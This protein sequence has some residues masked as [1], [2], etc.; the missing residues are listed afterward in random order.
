MNLLSYC[1]KET[2]AKVQNTRINAV[3]TKDI[4]K[5]GVLVYQDGKIGIS[6]AIGE[7]AEDKLVEN[8][9]R[10]LGT[11]ISYPYPLSKDRKDHRTYNDN[12][13]SA[14]ELMSITESV[15][16]TLRKEY[17]DFD[18]SETVST[19]EITIEMRNSEGLDLEYKDAYFSLGLILREKKSANL[20]DGLIMCVMPSPSI[21]SG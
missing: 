3:R 7:V 18:F 14:E 11:G 13:I 1:E 20:F 16:E 21:P 19:N 15:L 6:G 2:A 10:N 5:K 9:V 4:A 17:S 8:A 12:P